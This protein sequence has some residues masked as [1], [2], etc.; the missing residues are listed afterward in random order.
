M[1]K[2]NCGK[3]TEK[4]RNIEAHRKTE[5]WERKEKN[6]KVFDER[7]QQ[8]KKGGE[9]SSSVHAPLPTQRGLLPG[10]THTLSPCP[11]LYSPGY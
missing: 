11:A 2:R 10:G 1:L 3:K 4:G 8:Q 5:K 6:G 7:T 9:D